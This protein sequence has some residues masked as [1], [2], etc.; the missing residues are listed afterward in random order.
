MALFLFRF[1]PVLIPLLVYLVW[2]RKVQDRARVAG[3]P[4]PRFR[5]GPWFKAVVAS[6][7]TGIAIFLFFGLTQKSVKGD[8]IPPRLEGGKIV[9]GHVQ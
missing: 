9:E 7:I 2:M 8:Y 3:Q 5:D 1:W 6:L 4:I